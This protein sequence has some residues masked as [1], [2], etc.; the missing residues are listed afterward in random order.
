M[1]I[2]NLKIGDIIFPTDTKKI[3]EEEYHLK[4]LKIKNSTHFKVVEIW[5]Y[6]KV[7]KIKIIPSW[8]IINDWY[9]IM[10]LLKTEW[11]CIKKNNWIIS[12]ITIK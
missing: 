4:K 1:K 7:E 8:R 6:Y 9:N 11:Y 12:K 5:D 10:A 2:K 3:N